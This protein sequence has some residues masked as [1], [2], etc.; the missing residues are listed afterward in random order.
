MRLINRTAL[1]ASLAGGLAIALLTGLSPTTT[2]AAGENLI[3]QSSRSTEVVLPE[4]PSYGYT[5]S[6]NNYDAVNDADY[7]GSATVAAAADATSFDLRQLGA[8]PSVR[9]QGNHEACWAFAA[10]GSAMSE[11]AL[12]GQNNVNLSPAHLNWAVYNDRGIDGQRLNVGLSVSV[13]G[14]QT[15]GSDFLAAAAWSKGYGAQTEAAYPYRSA[16]TKLSLNQINSRQYQLDNAWILPRPYNSRGQFS[17]ANITAVQQKM[18]AEGALSTSYYAPQGQ[19]LGFKSSIYNPSTASIY[20]WPGNPI[21]PSNI[22]NH[23]VLLVGWDN[24][25]PASNFS[26]RPA[27]NGAWLVQNSWGTAADK[28]GYFWL[29]YY[30]VTIGESWLYD[31]SPADTS[32]QVL[33]LDDAMAGVGVGWL[34][35]RT[36]TG[37]NVFEVPAG[38]S[39]K[40]KSVLIYSGEPNQNYEISIYLNPGKTPTSGKLLDVNHTNGSSQTGSVT[41]AGWNQIGLENPPTLTAGSS[42]AVVVKTTSQTSNTAYLYGEEPYPVMSANGT[43]HS[44]ISYE[45]GQSFL[46]N[47]NGSTW[48]DFR[49]STGGRLGNLSIKAI[50]DSDLTRPTTPVSTA[51]S[52][53]PSTSE[54]PSSSAPVSPTKS[55]PTTTPSPTPTP[56][57]TST[58]SSSSPATSPRPGA[59]TASRWISIPPSPTQSWSTANRPSAEPGFSFLTVITSFF[60]GIFA[61]F[62]SMFTFVIWF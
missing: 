15:G 58:S 60:N 31:L 19:G 34:G 35:S 30:D 40:L 54:P 49:S 3:F 1:T 57:P 23:A 20:N 45:T 56:T 37:A 27:G 38:S 46:L 11:L 28:Q 2:Q 33:F 7:S 36:I 43:L 32:Q 62:M 25:Y 55:T 50:I 18:T 5:P 51:S 44:Y 24:D 48:S 42:F 47:S 17:F 53:A 41:Y 13:D 39:Q 21:N 6:Q 16:A 14:L 8:V 26:T 52:T 10:T 29:S 4:G 12:D 59:S 22:A 9:D 61:R